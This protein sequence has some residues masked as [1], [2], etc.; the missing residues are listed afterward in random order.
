[1][2]YTARAGVA[3]NNEEL[4]AGCCRYISIHFSLTLSALCLPVFVLFYCAWSFLKP[5]KPCRSA[6]IRIEVGLPFLRAMPERMKMLQISTSSLSQKH[7]STDNLHKE[8]AF[9]YMA[10]TIC[11][12]YDH[13]MFSNVFYSRRSRDISRLRVKL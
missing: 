9:G 8:P 12:L 13:F 11:H 1:M 3:A 4:I 2:H 5:H 6:D 7:L 10:L